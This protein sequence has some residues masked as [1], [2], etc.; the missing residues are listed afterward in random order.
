MT[1]AI[2][3]IRIPAEV[4]DKYLSVGRRGRQFSDDVAQRKRGVIDNFLKFATKEGFNLKSL[5]E[6]T[7][8]ITS[9]I[10]EGKVITK[11]LLRGDAT[12]ILPVNASDFIRTDVPNFVETK[13]EYK[14][15]KAHLQA[16]KPFLLVGPKGIAKTLS[17]DAF[18]HKNGLPL[19]R[20]DCSENTKEYNF[21]GKYLFIDNET[22][23]ELGVLPTAIEVANQNGI[24]V[25]VLEELNALTGAMQK[26]LNQLLDYRNSIFLSGINK[27]YSLKP[28]AQLLIVATMNPSDYGGT[29]EL[30]EDLKSRFPTW[31]LTYP[32]SRQ[33][34]RIL[35]TKDIEPSLV[36]K[37]ILLGQETR[38]AAKKGEI[39]YALSPRDLDA[40][41]DMHRA[42]SDSGLNAFDLSM[43]ECVFGKYETENEVEWIKQRIQSI[44]DKDVSDEEVEAR[45]S[46]WSEGE[47]EESD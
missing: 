12:R 34:A 31:R 41:F 36:K 15:F 39:E 46:K 44:F 27:T 11:P 4:L 17:V 24:A 2:K 7:T 14:R 25:L 19:V 43:E 21:K 32:S 29:H 1:D 5:M 10:K 30:N 23:F 37:M 9:T 13:K 35:N 26:V 42:Y 18:C 16:N 28:E 22:V 45:A 38:A 8:L 6:P 33:E 47:E 20:Y 3:P 40:F